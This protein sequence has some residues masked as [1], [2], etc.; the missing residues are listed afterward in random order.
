MGNMAQKRVHRRRLQEKGSP[1]FVCLKDR[2]RGLTIPELAGVP[3]ASV[4]RH[5]Q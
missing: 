3:V 5:I 2:A 4:D 1:L